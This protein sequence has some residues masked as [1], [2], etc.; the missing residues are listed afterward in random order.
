MERDLNGAWFALLLFGFVLE[1]WALF[2]GRPGDTLS[3]RLRSWFQV[4]RRPGWFAFALC[5]IVF[6]VWFWIHILL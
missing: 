6:S 4:H 3:E 5:W 1:M 2:N